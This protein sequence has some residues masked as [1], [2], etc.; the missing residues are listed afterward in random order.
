MREQGNV[1]GIVEHKDASEAQRQIN[2]I[3]TGIPVA[4]GRDLKRW[5]GMLNNDNAQGEFYI[6]DI[7]ALAHADGKKIETVHPSRLSEVEGVNNRLQLATL[8]RVF[9][10]EQSEKLLLAGVM[11]LDPARFD[12]RG[13]LVH[14]RDITIDANVL[15]K[16]TSSWVTG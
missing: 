9:Q 5:L 14:G 12:L 8:E 13:E 11:L 3:N 2:E 7:I 15:S 10:S 6:T 16:V 4:N 1:V